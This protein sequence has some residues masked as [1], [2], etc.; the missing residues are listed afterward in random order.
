MLVQI[1]AL[2]AVAMVF[3]VRLTASLVRASRRR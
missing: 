1:I 3:V 2:C